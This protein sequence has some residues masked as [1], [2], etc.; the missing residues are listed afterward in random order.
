MR[1]S[2]LKWEGSLKKVLFFKEEDGPS[3]GIMVLFV[4]QVH[5][6]KE[7]GAIEGQIVPQRCRRSLTGSQCYRQEDR[8][9]KSISPDLRMARHCDIHMIVEKQ[10]RSLTRMC[11][12]QR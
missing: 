2:R 4:K 6:Q 8:E 5:L 1:D 10:V 12:Q 9:E 3:S 11:K 7:V